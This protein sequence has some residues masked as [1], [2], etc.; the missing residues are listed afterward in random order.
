MELDARLVRGE[1]PRAG[2]VYLFQRAPR[3]LPPLVRL[4]QSYLGDIVWPVL[5]PLGAEAA[6]AVHD[7]RH[8][9][10]ETGR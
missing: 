8:A 6:E 4:D 1:T 5:G 7:A 2:A 10:E 3:A 9:E